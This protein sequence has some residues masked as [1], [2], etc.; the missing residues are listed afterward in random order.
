[1]NFAFCFLIAFPPPANP[2]QPRQT[3]R[4]KVWFWPVSHRFL[5]R[6]HRGENRL[7]LKTYRKFF[8]WFKMKI[9]MK[10]PHRKPIR[11]L[12]RFPQILK[13]YLVARTTSPAL[14]VQSSRWMFSVECRMLNVPH[15]PSLSPC[16]SSTPQL[17]TLC[18]FQP[19]PTYSTPIPLCVSVAKNPSPQASRRVKPSQAS[20]TWHFS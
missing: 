7:L 8:R 12:R 20:L 16:N 13:T 18:R 9:K 5:L 1:M 14:D 17:S 6:N 19:I 10:N 4:V 15:F 2:I 11:R 3:H